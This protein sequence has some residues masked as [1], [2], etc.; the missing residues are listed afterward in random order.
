MHLHFDVLFFDADRGAIH[1]GVFVGVAAVDFERSLVVLL[2]EV[3]GECFERLEL[4]FEDVGAAPLLEVGQE[5]LPGDG[6]VEAPPLVL[7]V[8]SVRC[9]RGSFL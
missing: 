5:I 7:A 2:F 4:L 6:E 8:T 1:R 3:V 9:S